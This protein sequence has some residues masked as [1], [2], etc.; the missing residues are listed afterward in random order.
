MYYRMRLKTR[1]HGHVYK[2]LYTFKVKTS[3]LAAPSVKPV[4]GG[5]PLREA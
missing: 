5:F 3:A 1:M 2:H 4:N